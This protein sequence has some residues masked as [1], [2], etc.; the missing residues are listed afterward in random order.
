M[1]EKTIKNDS[2]KIV[3]VG[4]FTLFPGD[5]C[6][7]DEANIGPGEEALKATKTISIT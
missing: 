6:K 7:M 4:D 5:Q 3:L 2:D 1:A